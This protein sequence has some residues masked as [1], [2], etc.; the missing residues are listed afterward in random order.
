M[1]KNSRAW[2]LGTGVYPLKVHYASIG[3]NFDERVAE[4]AGW[5]AAAGLAAVETFADS[6]EQMRAHADA[7]RSAGLLMPSAYV[8]ARLHEAD[9]RD[10]ADT[11]LK[12]AEHA[13]EILGA[14]ILTL[15]P[16]PIQWGQPLDK[17]D[18]ELRVQTGAL[19]YLCDELKSRGITLAYHTHD[20]EMRQGA[21][22]FHHMMLSTA[23]KPMRWC[24]DTHWIYRG[25]GNSDLAVEDAVKLYGQRIT[26]M[27]LRQSV[28]GVWSEVFGPG[29]LAH[30][31]WLSAIK[32]HP[33]AESVPIYLEQAA[34]TGTPVTLDFPERLRRSADYLKSLLP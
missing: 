6:P 21:R 20:P 29:D 3:A 18:A 10:R 19:R 27:H 2:L 7:F 26:A 17:T 34:E 12:L 23:D 1:A 8:N 22:E 16:E 13:R 33:R 32:S 14:G 30:H 25:C 9:W 5:I 15:N 28:G 24:L 4:A 31:H 11:T